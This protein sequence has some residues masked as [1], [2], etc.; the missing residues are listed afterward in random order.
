M[1]KLA[2]HG[3]PPAAAGLKALPLP[4]ERQGPCPEDERAVMT[5]LRDNR[6]GGLGDESSPA[7]LFE[8]AFARYQDAEYGLVV[9]NGT[10]SLELA[11]RAGGVR[12]GDQVLVPAITFVASASAVVSVGAVPVFVD[13]DPRT[14]Q[15][16]ASAMEAAITPSTRAIMVVHYGGYMADLDAI[17]PVA[18]KHDLLVVEDCAHAQGTSWRGKGAGSWGDFGSFSFQNSKS[19][20]AGEGGAVLTSSEALFER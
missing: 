2:I 17:L 11:L 10:V 3:G 6:V 15:M 20:A 16:S 4:W 13:V 9:A 5:A 14:A 8:K 18:R 7:V 19:L 12:P 1:P